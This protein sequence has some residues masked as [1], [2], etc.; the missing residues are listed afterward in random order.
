MNLIRKAIQINRSNKRIGPCLT[1]LKLRLDVFIYLRLKPE[2][3]MFYV[4]KGTLGINLKEKE[5]NIS[6][7]CRVNDQ[8][9]GK[10]T[11]FNKDP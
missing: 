6:S 8:M 11:Q 7:Y 3:M 4:P 9:T 2:A 1:A 5:H 10:P